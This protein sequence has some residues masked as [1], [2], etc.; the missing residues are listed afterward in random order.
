MR[1]KKLIKAA[2]LIASLLLLPLM[3]K[4]V[5]FAKTS[6]PDGMKKVCENESL[7]LFIDEEETDIAVLDK[8]SGKIW[9]SNPQDADEDSFASAYYKRFLKSQLQVT[10][11]NKNVQS[12]TMD[13]YN[14]SIMNGQ[15]EIEYT[16]DGVKINYYIGKAASMLTLPEVISQERLDSFKEK[17][18]KD[19]LKKINRN[20]TLIDPTASLKDDAKAY[21]EKYQGFG[22]KPFYVLRSGVK[23]YLKEELATYFEDAGYT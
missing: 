12:S 20:Y 8:A 15:F 19:Q 16:D 23:D 4:E 21:V 14:D 22:E 1:K 13:N 7:A 17:M 9:Y 5:A 3:F 2:I 18:S 11:F 6:A 10:Y